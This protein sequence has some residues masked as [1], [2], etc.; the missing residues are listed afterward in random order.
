MPQMSSECRHIM[1]SGVKCHAIALK[2]KPYCY[3]HTRLHRFTAAPP[4][5]PMDTIQLGVLEDRH[6]ILIAIAKVTDALCSGR[7]DTRRAGILLYSIQLATQNVDKS[8]VIPHETVEF[9]TETDTG[10]ELG[11]ANYICD[12]NKCAACPERHTCELCEIDEDEEEEEEKEKEENKEEEPEVIGQEL[13]LISQQIVRRMQGSAS[14]RRCPQPRNNHPSTK[15]RVPP[16]PR[17]WG[18]GGR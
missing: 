13:T 9:M 3:A 1:P 11:P 10:E 18:R 7:L 17:N 15:S 12:D 8:P 6:A 5:D 4:S 16:I 14:A 2:G